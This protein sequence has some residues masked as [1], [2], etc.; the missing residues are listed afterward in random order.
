MSTE[1]SHTPGKWDF[2]CDSYG[3]VRHSRKACVYTRM[4][5]PT[6]EVFVHVA[7]RIPQWEDAR[8]IAAAPELLYALQL[9]M[10]WKMRDGSPYCCPAGENEGDFD[11]P[12]EMPT[13]HA[14]GCS[15]ACAALAKAL[16]PAVYTPT[17]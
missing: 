5:T 1:K 15:D 4:M 17:A 6:G 12:K 3:K 10:C 16:S 13:I 11:Q 2:A 7:S 14:S 9:L 8:L